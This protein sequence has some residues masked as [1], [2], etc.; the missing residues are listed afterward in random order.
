M[1]RLA[2]EWQP[3]AGPQALTVEAAAPAA[4]DEPLVLDFE[5]HAPAW[6]QRTIHFLQTGELPEEHEEAE[7]VAVGPA[8]TSFWMMPYT[9]GGRTT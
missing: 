8:C 3:P 6:A 5:P 2:G 1:P 9:E 4:I 7:K